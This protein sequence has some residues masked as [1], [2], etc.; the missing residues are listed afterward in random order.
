MSNRPY[1]K[2]PIPSPSGIRPGYLRKEDAAKYL[3]EAD[4]T[5]WDPDGYQKQLDKIN[6]I[7]QQL[8]KA[9]NNK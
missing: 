2:E 3:K 1:D 5:S 6:V 7:E 9:A 4:M 8:A